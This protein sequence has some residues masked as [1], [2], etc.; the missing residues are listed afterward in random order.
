MVTFNALTPLAGV[1]VLDMPAYDDDDGRR[2]GCGQFAMISAGPERGKK[3]IDPPSKGPKH[4]RIYYF[5]VF[6][7]CGTH[8]LTH[9]K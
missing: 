9:I 6:G 5:N 2:D 3:L 7:D 1:N 8:A 4:A